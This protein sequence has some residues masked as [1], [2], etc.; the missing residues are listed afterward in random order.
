MRIYAHRGASA[1]RPENTLASFRRAIEVGSY[2]V[3]L[4]VHLS[5]DAIPVVIHDTTVDRTTGGSGDVAS[6]DVAELKTLDAGDGETIPTLGDV[7]HTVAG[8]AH[9][10]I[11]VKA[12]KAADAVLREVSRHPGLTWVMSSFDHDVLRY[13]HSLDPD[14]RLWPLTVGASDD[15]LDAVRDLG[16]DVVAISDQGFDEDIATYLERQGVSSWVWTV[17]DPERAAVLATWPVIGICTDNPARLL[18]ISRSIR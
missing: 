5:R 13:V 17:N 4:D 2:G 12:A 9:V 1:E 8:K 11:E 6:F 10:D 15:A 18:E 3:E 16:G 7:L 14:A